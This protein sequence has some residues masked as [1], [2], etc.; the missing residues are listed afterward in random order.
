M[1]T[2]LTIKFI[3]DIGDGVT[4]IW[5]R[6]SNCDVFASIHLFCNCP[7]L[8]LHLWCI[9]PNPTLYLWC[10]CHDPQHCIWPNLMLHSLCICPDLVMYLPQS[11]FLL[12]PRGNTQQAKFGPGEGGEKKS[13]GQKSSSRSKK[14]GEWA[15]KWAKNNCV[16]FDT[17]TPRPP[18]DVFN[19]LSSSIPTY[20][21]D[22]LND[23][24]FG[25]LRGIDAA[26][27]AYGLITSNFLTQG[28]W[29]LH[30][31]GQLPCVQPPTS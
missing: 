15:R 18:W 14:R 8:A 21:A 25:L 9:C 23:W 19:C 1:T 28:C 22:R 7:D 5:T 31:I 27:R 16:I 17:P 3:Q 10:I 29:R 20:L 12:S 11:S 13:E 24:P 6:P 26:M 30:E 2:C 4:I